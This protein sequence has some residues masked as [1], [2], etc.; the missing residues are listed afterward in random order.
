MPIQ[1]ASTFLSHASVHKKLVQ[2]VATELGRRGVLAW[3]DKDELAPGMELSSILFKSAERQLTMTAFISDESLKS[4]WC[5]EELKPCLEAANDDISDKIIPVYLGDP[6]TLISN[7]SLLKADWLTP[8]GSR[9]DKLGEVVEDIHSADAASIAAKIAKVHYQRLKTNKC[10]QLIV[11]LDQRGRGERIG[12]PD[13]LPKN[14]SATSWPA[15]VFRPDRG[16]RSERQVLQEADWKS[17]GDCVVQALAQA[18]GTRRQREIYITG[19]MQLACAWLLGSYFNRTNGIKLVSHNPRGDQTLNIDMSGSSYFSPPAHIDPTTIVWDET[20]PDT[21]SEKI[22]VYLGPSH[23]LDAVR[24]YRRLTSDT[25][26]L[27]MWMTERKVIEKEEEVRDLARWLCTASAGRPT[28]IYTSL[29]TH[30]LTQLAAL[31]QLGTGP[32]TFMERD[33]GKETYYACPMPKETSS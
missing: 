26:P 22:S 33:H 29:P 13:F 25:T 32:V 20:N 21:D 12:D 31:I 27:A 7:S 24:K 17:Y 3:L 4:Q 28:R 2:K 11:A 16:D 19:N 30:V 1:Y 23:Y 18:L 6:H 5:N 14:W 10:S 8:D 15:L 9:T